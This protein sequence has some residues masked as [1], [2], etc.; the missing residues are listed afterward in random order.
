MDETH[1]PVRSEEGLHGGDDE[2]HVV[3]AGHDVAHTAHR[4]G[5]H[6]LGKKVARRGL[7]DLE[8]DIE[9]GRGGSQE[10]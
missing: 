4:P 8:G 7:G 2:E 3:V 1:L 6:P 10:A 5:A 9:G